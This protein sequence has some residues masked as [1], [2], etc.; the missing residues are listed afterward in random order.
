VGRTGF[1]GV[2]LRKTQAFLEAH[3][4]GTVSAA[5]SPD[6]AIRIFE[7]NSI[8]RA[9]ARLGESHFALYGNGPYKASRVDSFLG[10]EP[11]VCARFADVLAVVRQW[12]FVCRGSFACSTPWITAACVDRLD[13]GRPVS[14]S[15]KLGNESVRSRRITARHD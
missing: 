15:L 12:V 8:M 10:R 6:G 11:A 2:A 5:F 1:N 7:S 14:A 4:F 3:P 13:W 9:V